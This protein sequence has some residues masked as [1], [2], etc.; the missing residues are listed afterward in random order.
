MYNGTGLELAHI[1]DNVMFEYMMCA[2]LSDVIPKV[3]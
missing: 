1:T 2:L 3:V